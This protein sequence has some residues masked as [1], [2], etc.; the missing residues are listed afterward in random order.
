[1]RDHDRQQYVRHYEACLR[2]HG[3]ISEALGCGVHGRQA[4]RFAVLAASARA[5]PE[6]SVL[7]VGCGF[8]DLYAYLRAH[9]WRGRYT[10][11]DLVPGFLATARAR[12]PDLDV[13][14]LDISSHEHS[15]LDTYDLVLASGLFNIALES[16]D[17]L[18]H[19][20]MSLM[21]MLAHT[22]TPSGLVAVDF[23]SAW[24][25]FEKPGDWHTSPSQAL[26][27]GRHLTRRLA[28]RLDYMPYEFALFLHRDDRV[29]ERNV[30]IGHEETLPSP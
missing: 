22:R 29:S 16:G 26:A 27:I 17:M 9:G 5:H 3:P 2:T 30:F 13:R 28:L 8:A 6:S 11:I 18:D 23:M 1:M 21:N 7:D 19:I 25:D 10:G 12:E 4:E 14:A 24:V 15:A 20:E